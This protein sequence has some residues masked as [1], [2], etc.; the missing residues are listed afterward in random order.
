MAFSGP[1]SKSWS[2]YMIWTRYSQ[3]PKS[4]FKKQRTFYKVI[5]S[6]GFQGIDYSLSHQWGTKSVPSLLQWC[7]LMMRSL[8]VAS[9]PLAIP[10]GFRV[11][12]RMQSLWLENGSDNL[13]MGFQNRC[14][15]K[16]SE[17]P[18]KGCRH[19]LKTTL[20]ALRCPWFK[21]QTEGWI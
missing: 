1:S 20:Q 19:R 16:S 8:A 15:R 3:P 12:R 2:A 17:K 7:H 11:T 6:E 13:P 14:L 5:A 4:P 10:R 9:G 21:V 18:P